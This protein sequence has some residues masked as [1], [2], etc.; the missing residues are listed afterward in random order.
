ME[1]MTL[2][3]LR[4]FRDQKRSELDR[5]D[6]SN[7]DAQIIVAMGTCG[8]AAGAKATFGAVLDEL[9]KRQIG[10]VL[11][12]QVGCMGLCHSEPNVEVVVPGMPTVIYGKVDEAL[13]RRIVHDHV[14]GKQLVD[15]AICDRPAVDIVR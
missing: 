14:I 10:S 8:I 11:V 13:A 9:E 4:K 1:K 12:R 7:K 5:R 15:E 2:A 6:P 3:D